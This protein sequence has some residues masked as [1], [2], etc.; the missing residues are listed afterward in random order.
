MP[1]LSMVFLA[2]ALLSWAVAVIS[3]MLALGHRRP[4]LSIGQFL[5]RGYLI[6]SGANFTDAGQ[7]HQKRFLLGFLA[8]FL[9]AGG[10]VVAGVVGAQP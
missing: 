6:F 5:F 4:D 8:F 7:A 10:A 1:V 9:C 3:W 2:L